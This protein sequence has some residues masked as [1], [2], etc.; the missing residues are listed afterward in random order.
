MYASHHGVH[1]LLCREVSQDENRAD[2]DCHR[3]ICV[4]PMVYVMLTVTGI[5]HMKSAEEVPGEELVPSLVWR[6]HVAV[7]LPSPGAP[8]QPRC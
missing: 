7:V 6:V 5:A 8:A 4:L 1:D 2:A 3:Q